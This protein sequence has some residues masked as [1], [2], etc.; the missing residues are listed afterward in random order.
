MRYYHFL[1]L[2]LHFLFAF[3]SYAGSPTPIIPAISIEY[4]DDQSAALI[5]LLKSQYGLCVS[6][7][8]MYQ[9]I[10][11]Q[12]I[13]WDAAK[14][15]LPPGYFVGGN[16]QPEPDWIKEKVGIFTEKQYLFGDKYA[17]YVYRIKY[18]FSNDG[19]CRLLKTESLKIEK[20]D[21]VYR[22]MITLSEKIQAGATPGSG[23]P[24]LSS[25]YKYKQVR[26]MDSR[27]LSNRQATANLA[28]LKND[29]AFAALISQALSDSTVSRTPGTKRQANQHTIDLMDKAFQI[30][31]S[32]ANI[33]S[34]PLA[35]DEHIVLG[36]PCD[37]VSSKTFP[38]RAWYW[39]PM[40]T[41]P[42]P[43]DRNII[44]KT[45]STTFGAANISVKEAIRFEVKSSLDDA[46]FVPEPDLLRNN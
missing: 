23:G 1:L 45:E 24:T 7:K 35:N 6:E 32:K 21:G 36:Q 18:T 8:R 11:S 31:V 46:I 12:G 15:D 2:L 40:H 42:G 33:G 29:P 30:S 14:K 39:Q 27:A 4:L 22:Y 16:P 37:I 41:Y 5:P 28:P 26:R 44:L 17:Q 3:S 38:G 43:V 34:L 19:R 9:S 25:Q 20:D 10:Q 13:A